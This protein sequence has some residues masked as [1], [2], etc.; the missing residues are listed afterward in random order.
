[1]SEP[2]GPWRRLDS[3]FPPNSPQGRASR[4][5]GAVK[6]DGPGGTGGGSPPCMEKVG[7]GSE[8]SGRYSEPGY[9]DLPLRAFLGL[10]ADDQPAP[11]VPRRRRSG[12]RW[13][14]ACARWRRGCRVGSSP[15]QPSSRPKPGGWRTRLPARPSRRRGLPCRD[16]RAPSARRAPAGTGAP[17]E[18]GA[19]AATD[20]DQRRRR[21]AAA[22]SVAADVPMRIA[23]IGA[24]VTALA[25]R[26]AVHGH[27]NLHGDAITAALLA[28]AGTRL[29][30]RPG[31]D[32]P[33]R[34]RIR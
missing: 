1:M 5:R 9:L 24:Q 21:L 4:E 28:E 16:R 15:K 26:L 30:L 34:R 13:P 10:L 2:N 29:G 22:L 12:S 27:P 33:V 32:Q 20:D 25:A 17:A 11:A 19:P 18:P 6:G 3:V 8:A 31:P 7:G 23:E 14:P